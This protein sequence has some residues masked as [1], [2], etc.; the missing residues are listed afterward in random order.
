M[1][2]NLDFFSQEAILKKVN[3]LDYLSTE[4]RKG[5]AKVKKILVCL[6]NLNRKVGSF[7]EIPCSSMAIIAFFLFIFVFL[8][9]GLILKSLASKSD[10]FPV[11]KNN[12][13]DNLF[14]SITK[15]FSSEPPEFL[16]VGNQSLKA[17]SPP[18]VFSSQVLGA[19]VAGYEEEEDNKDV[20]TEYI[21]EDGDTLWSL[22][23]K[24]NI[25]ID[26]I[27]W[28]N[29]L[30]EKSTIKPG[31]KLVILPVSG[32]V[33]IVKSGDTVSEIAKIYKGK[34]QEIIS[35][36]KIANEN[37]IYVGD[38]LIIPGGSMSA[39][40]QPVP[41]GAPSAESRFIAP[42]SSPYIITQGGHGY[43]DRYYGYTAVDFSYAGY[44][45][46]RSVFAAAGGIIQK[47][48]Y[49]RIAGNYVRILHPN[50]V[51]TFYGHLSGIAVKKNEAVGVGDVIGFIGNT[52]YTIGR[53]GCHLHFEVRGAKN[54]FVK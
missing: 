32:T 44:A 12:E 13:K 45:C 25:S 50:G 40:A 36:N 22:A 54:P 17:S 6:I 15:K 28:A 48:G 29:N 4:L 7:S 41:V 42:V 49:D 14:I 33:H 23:G 43:Y 21:V 26:T 51:V 20:I 53:T 16:L 35:F 1:D 37:D 5:G 31:D 24:F 27:R 3:M 39:Q 38:I 30:S 47:T 52:G 2:K 10:F 18:N 8:G 9:S 19:L 46:G 11:L 34:T